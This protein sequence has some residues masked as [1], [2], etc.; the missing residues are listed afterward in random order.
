MQR[1]RFLAASSAATLLPAGLAQAS[2]LPVPASGAIGFNV[3]Q[4]GTPC[5]EHHLTFTQTGDDLKV[6]IDIELA[7]RAALIPYKYSLQATEHYTNGVFQSLDSHAVDRGTVKDVHCHRQGDGYEI[8]GTTMPAYTG[9]A[10]TLPLSYWNKAMLTATIV[11]IET[12]HS[13]K[14]V[15]TSPGWSQLPTAGGGSITAQRYDLSGK[16]R[17]SVWY[18]QSNAWCG[19]AFQFLFIHFSYQKIV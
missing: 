2:T 6:D 10:D 11:N 9:P 4:D 17:L 3:F 15:V 13:Y 12:A 16:L 14:E 5:G 7:G 19:L 18:D 1:R 8:S